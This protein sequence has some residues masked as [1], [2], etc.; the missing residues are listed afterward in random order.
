V[1]EPEAAFSG[2]LQPFL[3]RLETRDLTLDLDT[4]FRLL[5]HDAGGDPVMVDVQ[6]EFFDR[7]YWNPSETAATDLGIKSALGGSVVYDSHVHGSWRRMRDRTNARHGEAASLG[8][9]KWVQSYVSERDAWL[10]N[11]AN[12]LLRRT[13]YRMEEFEK[14]IKAKKWALPLPLKVRGITISKEALEGEPAVRV[15]AEGDDDRHLRF[16][17]PLMTGE[18]VAEVQRALKGAGFNLEPDGIFGRNTEAAVRRFQSR[19]G[20]TSDGIVGH[21]T[22]AALGI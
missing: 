6:D 9:K 15:S 2:Q 21:A 14:L 5:L 20:L 16:A 8:E 19:E 17:S 3:R 7:V 18:D 10:R 1:Q 12:P 4:G 22:R 11:H 13:V